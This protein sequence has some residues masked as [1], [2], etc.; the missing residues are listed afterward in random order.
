MLQIFYLCLYEASYLSV[1]G[2]NI[3]EETRNFARNL[4]EEYLER[5]VDQIDFTMMIN[6]ALELPIHRR[7]LRLE[8]RWFIPGRSE[9]CI[10]VRKVRIFSYFI[11]SLSNSNIDM[12]YSVLG[13]IL[14][15]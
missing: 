11:S 4:L 10:N 6:R 5:T 7:M 12:I 3:L 8:A 14:Y 2:E 15:M 1:E 9:I 13:L